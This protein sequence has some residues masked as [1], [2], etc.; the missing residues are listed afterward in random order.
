MFVKEKYYTSMI[1][2]LSF[3]GVVIYPYTYTKLLLLNFFRSF[4]AETLDKSIQANGTITI[5]EFSPEIKRAQDLTFQTS[6]H[7]DSNED[8]IFRAN[9][10]MV[11]REPVFEALQQYLTALE[12]I[13]G[14]S[15]LVTSTANSQDSELTPEKKELAKAIQQGKC[16][17]KFESDKKQSE[18]D[19]KSKV[20]VS[21]TTLKQTITFAADP[22][23]LYDILVNPS[24]MA[25]WARGPPRA[26]SSGT[27][28][29]ST[30]TLSLFDGNVEFAFIDDLCIPSSKIEMTWRFKSWPTDFPS[31]H[32]TLKLVPDRSLV[33]LELEQTGILSAE[34]DRLNT[35]WREYYWNPIKHI[36][37]LG[38]DCI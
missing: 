6:F 29:T 2:E 8:P 30:S 21:T 23:M 9:L 19:A 7:E 4:L 25:I 32:V 38:T 15:L 5:P 16:E 3:S 37:G 11:L 35:N 1:F 26:I 13:Q 31:S 24:K 28:K 27:D 10:A 17:N 20:S 12:Q 36:F 34:Y 18:S 22:A 33:K 14:A